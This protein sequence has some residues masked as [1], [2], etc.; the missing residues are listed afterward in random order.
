[1]NDKKLNPFFRVISPVID[2]LMESP[3]RNKM[4]EVK[5]KKL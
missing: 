5:G 2:M 4:K 3:I 1:M